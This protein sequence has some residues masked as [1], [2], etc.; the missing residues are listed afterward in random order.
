VYSIQHYGINLSVTCN[1]SVVFFG[2]SGF[3]PQKTDRNDIAEILLKV[4]LDTII[5]PALFNMAEH[6]T[7]IRP[8]ISIT[9]QQFNY[10]V[11]KSEKKSYFSIV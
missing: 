10:K 8:A 3:L 1:R 2:Y 11:G 4:A 5:K 6:E 9:L 7:T